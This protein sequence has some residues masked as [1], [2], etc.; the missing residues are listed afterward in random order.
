M[1]PHTS[2]KWPMLYIYSII[3]ILVRVECTK[4]TRTK[5]RDVNA[6]VP[7]CVCLFPSSASPLHAQLILEWPTNKPVCLKNEA[8][9]Q[10]CF[11]K[12]AWSP[13]KK[14]GNFL[15]LWHSP[16]VSIPRFVL[17]QH[18]HMVVGLLVLCRQ[19]TFVSPAKTDVYLVSKSLKWWLLDTTPF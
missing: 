1:V 5:G 12:Q 2:P 9:L 4:E 13:C 15:F 10:L 11:V 14:A 8:V 6:L 19:F 17:G 18:T 16:L 7:V 3:C